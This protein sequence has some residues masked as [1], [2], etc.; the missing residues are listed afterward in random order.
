MSEKRR[1]KPGERMQWQ[2]IH[3]PG[4]HSRPNNNIWW[5]VL[6]FIIAIAIIFSRC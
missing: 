3:I 2:E 1:S 4:K 6:I 5:M